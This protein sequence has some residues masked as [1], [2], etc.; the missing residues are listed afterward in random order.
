MK[1][2]LL[3]LAVLVG[4]LLSLVA[5]GAPGDARAQNTTAA[6]EGAV[7]SPDG[8]PLPGANILAI[9]QPT[10]T[11]YGATTNEEGRY[12]LQGLRVGGPYTIEASFVGYQ[13]VRE[14][15][16]NLQLDQ[17]RTISFELQQAT[18]ELEAVEVIGETDRLIDQNQMGTATNVSQAEIEAL[19]TI[20]RSVQDFLRLSPFSNGNGALAGRSNRYNSIQVDGATLNDVF[21]LSDTGA[22]GGQAGSQP[23]SL[24]VIKEFNIEVAPYDVRSA[25]FTG[26]TINAITKSGTNNWEGSLNFLGRGDGLV[27][28]LPNDPYTGNFG[29]YFYTG[30]LGGPIIEDNVFFFVGGE[31]KREGRPQT[32]QVGLDLAQDDAFEVNPAQLE[33]IR[34][35]A[36]NQYQYD[37]GS[38]S[39]LTLRIDNRKLFGKLSWNINDRHRLSLRHNY[40]YAESGDGISRSSGGFS[41]SG[42]RFVNE[43]TQNSTVARLKSTLGPSLYNEA[44]LVYTRVRNNRNPQGDAFPASTICLDADCNEDVTLGVERYSQ[45]NRLNQDIFEITDNLTYTRGAHTFT[46]GTSNRIFHFNNLFIRDFFGTYTFRPFTRG[47]STVSGIEAF[48][49]GQP[50]EYN[51]SYATDQADSERPAA[52]FTAYQLGLY[53]QDEWE[54]T[55][56]L[57]LTGGLRVDAPFLPQEPLENP[58]VEDAFGRSTTD[59]ASGNLLWQPRLGFNFNFG[60]D[61]ITQVRGGVGI[62]SGPPPYVWI[63][64]QYTTTG[65]NISR[66]SAS[67]NP[68]DD[69]DS[70]EQF[71]SP[72]P[73]EQPRPGED[74]RLSAQGA[75]EVNLTSEDFEYPQTLRANLALD[76]E[77]PAGF[78][79]TLEGIYSSTLNGIQYRNINLEQTGTSKYGRPIYGDPGTFTSFGR[80][81]AYQNEG[82]TNVLLLEN[83]DQGY[84]YSG[85]VRLQ[86]R[87]ARGLSGSVS[88]TYTQ[89]KNI[90]PGTSDQAVSQWRYL[91]SVDPN[92]PQLATSAYQTPHR[93]LGQLTY[94]FDWGTLF[95]GGDRFTTT[96]GLVYEGTS[97][98]PFTWTYFGDPNADATSNDLVYVPAEEDDVFMRNPDNWNLLDAFIE[99]HEALNEAR[100]SI[101]D[102]NTARDP[103]THLIDLQLSQQIATF[104]GQDIKLTANLENALNLLDSEWGRIRESSFGEKSAWTFNRYITESDVGSR[105]SGRIVT[106]DDVGK[107]VIS[108]SD[109]FDLEPALADEEFG[110]SFLSRWRLQFGVKYTF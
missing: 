13:S 23:I 94:R 76:H 1:S 77:L 87:Q 106:E 74:P 38:F 33:D 81:T 53:A 108:V 43:S 89:A 85:T 48:R 31:L 54:A 82:F 41:L 45:A 18:E 80:S 34:G 12:Y 8:D 6:I 104:E 86:R 25:G 26:G 91:P 105:V 9:H 58:D 79:L 28:D 84:E 19:P 29:E 40:V 60:E 49:L 36:Q 24:S 71:F 98:S 64:N 20:S 27:G 4:L 39:P 32:T 65:A 47:D 55:E 78:A 107:P 63:S 59:V 88:Y 101:I 30:T 93:F 96:L 75:T 56:R 100:G 67:F 44:R 57:T 109:E 21:G 102:R 15:G 70:D 66:V 50:S 83:T 11:R 35:V 42:R 99:G 61:E 7:S 68:A 14:T 2:L 10:G 92:N 90:N 95:D 52:E 17:T 72:S 3:K 16:V 110:T 103:W 37:P 46:F 69:F 62:F 73:G 22:P 5:L 97:G 51:L